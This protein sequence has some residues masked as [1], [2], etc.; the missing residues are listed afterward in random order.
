MALSV[1]TPHVRVERRPVPNS[2]KSGS[3]GEGASAQDWGL[4][5]AGVRD[6]PE[7][8]AMNPPAL[9]GPLIARAG[10][11][12]DRI[13]VRWRRSPSIAS[14]GSRSALPGHP[15]RVPRSHCRWLSRKADSAHDCHTNPRHGDVVL[16]GLDRRSVRRMA[17]RVQRS[18][19]TPDRRGGRIALLGRVN[20][21]DRASILDRVRQRRYRLD[22]RTQLTRVFLQAM[23]SLLKSGR[24]TSARA[25]PQAT[26]ARRVP[27][28]SLSWGL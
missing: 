14:V 20:A 10:P 24:I 15:P 6:R 17:D 5:E 22:Q 2:T 9:A 4:P 26:L 11:I 13:G 25:A 16:R 18:C 3:A 12:H 28:L 27:D 8:Q 7:T 19:R 21:N 23:V 1:S